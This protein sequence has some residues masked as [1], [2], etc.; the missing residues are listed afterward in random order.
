MASESHRL[1]WVRERVHVLTGRELLE[2]IRIVADT[3]DFMALDR[4]QVLELGGELFLI[5]GTEREKRFGLVDEPK[6]W[7]KRAISLETGRLY[8]LKMVF[9]ESFKAEIGSQVFLC[10]RSAEKEARVLETTAGDQRFM[11]GRGVRDARG[12]LVR[13]LEFIRGVDLYSKVRA[14]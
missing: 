3:T 9:Q 5:T 4:D 6:H 8:V 1:P 11:Q 7:V 13:V 12:N 14:C 2:P 10:V